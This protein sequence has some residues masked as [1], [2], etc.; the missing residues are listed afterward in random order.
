MG[1][2]NVL[3][4]QGNPD[5]GI[6]QGLLTPGQYLLVPSPTG[7]KLKK[8]KRQPD[9]SKAL[10]HKNNQGKVS[11]TKEFSQTLDDIYSQSD[12]DASGGLSR[13]EFNLFNWR[14][15]GEEVQACQFKLVTTLVFIG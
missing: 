5:D 11:L 7:C 13:V 8:R 6:W 3:L 1:R 12:L 9:T 10:V 4:P 14:T 2:T 15:S